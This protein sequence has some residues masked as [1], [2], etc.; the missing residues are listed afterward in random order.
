MMKDINM[1]KIAVPIETKQ[2]FIRRVY[3]VLK[4]TFQVPGD[5]YK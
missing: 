1:M 4:F 5:S 2:V 3:E